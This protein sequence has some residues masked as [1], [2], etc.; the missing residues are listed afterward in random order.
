MWGISYWV[1]PVISGLCWFGMLWGMLIHWLT[2][3]RPKYPSMEP[4]QRI[5]YISDVGAFYLKP[6]FIT[7]AVVTTIFLDASFLSEQF[8]RRRGRL[9]ANTSVAQK[10]LAGLS[11]V[12]AIVGTV[13]L[14]CLSILDT[15]RHNRLH[16]IFLACF[17]GGYVVSAV[18]I[19]AEYQRLGIHFR[20]HR[21]LRVSFWLKLTFILLEV[22]LAVAF[23]VLGRVK[24]RNEA[25][26]IEWTVAFVFTLYVFSFFIDLLPATKTKHNRF[27]HG[28]QETEMQIERAD[29]RQHGS[30]APG[31]G[32][33]RNTY[34]SDRTVGRND[35][36][37]V[38]G[39]RAKKGRFF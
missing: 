3:G 22:A 24:R 27:G 4:T 5:A 9:V 25:A 15:Y 23:G 6:L 10:V 36:P 21:I 19:C 30:G 2:T 20:E 32:A 39:K 35:E 34:E 37:V 38:G 7:G 31:Y 12:A 17:I 29:S 8:L 28:Q 11:I 33:E 14:I 1:F 13:G 16:N 18:F 26:I